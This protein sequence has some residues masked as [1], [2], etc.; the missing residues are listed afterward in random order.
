MV[1]II[2]MLDECD[3]PLRRRTYRG[4]DAQVVVSTLQ[5]LKWPNEIVGNEQFSASSSVRRFREL[6]ELRAPEFLAD[7]LTLSFTL[8]RR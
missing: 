7:G 5:S 3:A 4:I 6:E 8:T 2:I 1:V